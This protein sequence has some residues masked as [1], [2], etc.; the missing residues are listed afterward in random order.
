MAIAGGDKGN[1]GIRDQPSFTPLP[2]QAGDNDVG[3]DQKLKTRNQNLMRQNQEMMR[4]LSLL[5][6]SATAAPSTTTGG[7]VCSL[8]SRSATWEVLPSSL[9][10]FV[11][12]VEDLQL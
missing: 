10:V 4:S 12:S 6:Q 7:E 11:L 2:E 8:L 1:R 5:S 9:T 3:A